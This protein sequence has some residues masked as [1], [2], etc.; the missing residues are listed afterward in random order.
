MYV[1]KGRLPV[2]PQP[3]GSAE[4]FETDNTRLGRLTK[5]SM[6]DINC[7]TRSILFAPR[8]SSSESFLPNVK[9]LRRRRSMSW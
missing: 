6:Q 3:L 4:D 1:S 8:I 7:A 2:T 5:G 9:L